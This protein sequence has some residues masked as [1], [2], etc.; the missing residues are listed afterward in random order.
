MGTPGVRPVIRVFLAK[1]SQARRGCPRQ[2]GHDTESDF[3][4]IEIRSRCPR[5]PQPHARSRRCDPSRSRYPGGPRTGGLSGGVADDRIHHRGALPSSRR[6]PALWH[7]SNEQG[8]QV[9]RK[10]KP[11]RMGFGP[12][13]DRA[14]RSRIARRNQLIA[15]TPAGLGVPFATG[16]GR[17][18]T[19]NPSRLCLFV[20]TPPSRL[21]TI[22]HKSPPSR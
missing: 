11:R 7:Q 18:V 8:R 3:D 16:C 13:R 12:D 6:K 19:D 4:P 14:F 15:G 20:F 5:P 2:V 1:P 21:S 10:T 22:L 17:D 9:N